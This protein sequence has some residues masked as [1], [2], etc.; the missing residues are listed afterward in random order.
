MYMHAH[1]RYAQALA[2]IG[3]AERFFHAL[4]RANPIGLRELV[5]TATLRQSKLLLLELGRGVHRPLP[6]ERR[7]RARAR[8]HDR[9]RRRLARLFE[10]GRHPVQPRHPPS[11][12]ACGW[13]PTC[14]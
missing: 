5:P 10:R 1:L 6:G 14:C 2:H 7:V 8:G 9:S 13:K 11:C 3:E 4:C 12:S